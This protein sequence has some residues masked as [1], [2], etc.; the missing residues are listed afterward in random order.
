MGQRVKVCCLLV[1]EQ[2]G[3]MKVDMLVLGGVGDVG[4]G[5]I[6]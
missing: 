1:N 6:G 2:V 4:S 3:Q 5:C